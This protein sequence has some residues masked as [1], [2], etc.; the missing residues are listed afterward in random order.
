MRKIERARSGADK[1]AESL[2]SVMEQPLAQWERVS[3]ENDSVNERMPAVGAAFVHGFAVAL[4]EAE[5]FHRSEAIELA[6]ADV[7]AG[8]LEFLEGGI[9]GELGVKRE[10]FAEMILSGEIVGGVNLAELERTEGLLAVANEKFAER[11]DGMDFC[12]LMGAG[13]GAE[14]GQ[15]VGRA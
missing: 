4:Y 10:E 8:E 2:T 5:I 11:A 13:D 1:A 7:T 14:R 15:L 12:E 6:L 9:V 3:G